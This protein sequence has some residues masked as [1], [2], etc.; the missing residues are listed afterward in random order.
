MGMFY[1]FSLGHAFD[2]GIRKGNIFYRYLF[3]FIIVFRIVKWLFSKSK[4]QPL[5]EYELSPGE[6]RVVVT[7]NGKA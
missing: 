6:Y 3:I 7:E 5:Q 4:P 2:K 1:K